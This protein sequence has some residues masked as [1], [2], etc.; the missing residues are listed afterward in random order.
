M[1]TLLRSLDR[2]V[3][4]R[5]GEI[6]WARQE[7]HHG[8]YVKNSTARRNPAGTVVEHGPNRSHGT[9]HRDAKNGQ[10]VD[11]RTAAR[12]PNTTVTEKG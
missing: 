9:H 10:F 1:Q 4:G 5:H 11:G 2:P 6:R 8:R 7:C 3:G 12:R